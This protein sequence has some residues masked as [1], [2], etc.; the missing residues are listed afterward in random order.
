MSLLIDR[1]VPS[2]PR[3]RNMRRPGRLSQC[4]LA[5]G[6]AL[7][8]SFGVT[9]RLSA[10]HRG[11]FGNHD[12]TSSAYA[13][14]GSSGGSPDL[15]RD[16][17]DVDGDGRAD[18]C[19][20]VTRNKLRCS[21]GSRAGFSTFRDS[22]R[23][24]PGL[25]DMLQTF[26][27]VNADG[28]AD[29]CRFVGGTSP[30]LK[31]TVAYPTGQFLDIR[32]YSHGLDPGYAEMPRFMADVNGDGGADYCRFV[33]A[34]DQRF[35]SCALAKRSTIWWAGTFGDYDVNSAPGFSGLDPGYADM[36]TFMADVTAD[37]RADYCRF[38]GEDNARFL[39][40]AVARPAAGFGNHD[41]ISAAGF[42]GLDPGRGDMPRFMADANGDGRADYCRFVG[43]DPRTYFSCALATQS[44]RF[45]NYDLNSKAGSRSF[46]PGTADWPRLMV[47]ADGDSRSDYCRFVYKKHW[48][49]SGQVLSCARA[50]PPRRPADVPDFS[51]V[52]ESEKIDNIAGVR[53][54]LAILWDPHR[55][56]HPA[57]P[58]SEIDHLLFGADPSVRDWYRENSGGKIKLVRERVLGWYDAD[59]PADHYWD[60]ADHNGTYGDGWTDGHVEKWAE[61]IRRADADFDFAAYD[62]ND[63]KE[64]EVDELG[65]LIV[66]PQDGPFGTVRGTAGRQVPPEPLVVDGVKVPMIAEWYTGDPANLG[67]PAH[68][69]SHLF[70]GTPDLYM[71][72]RAWPFAAHTYSIMDSSYTTTHFDPFVKL[73]AGW[74]NY[75]VVT[76]ALASGGCC[77]FRLRDV[78]TTRDAIILYDPD[79]GPGEYFVLENRWRGSSYDTGR[80]MRGEGI[81]MD[82]LA[83][84]HII[85]DP[86]LLPL[87]NP[88]I[89][90]EGE[91]GRRGIR[92]VRANGGVPE[93][94]DQ[95]LFDD[96]GMLLGDDTS[97]ASLRWID[98][99]R[100]GFEIEVLS[101]AGPTMEIAVRVPW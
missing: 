54:V 65:V 45:G 101:A 8:L 92:L 76:P 22:P 96:E 29:Y 89:G 46:D 42:D 47:D 75:T 94:D 53:R 55:P 77:A 80:S 99:S 95:A 9:A 18:Y 79:R 61:A 28:R 69:L 16:I 74:L 23:I 43:E 66:I 31:C 78:Q 73:K 90:A 21:L 83:V 38:V 26:A 12:I 44:G 93:D 27:D 85:E 19:R 56:G 49:F 39:S 6:L 58:V 72:G 32:E 59:K 84:W 13:L 37:G 2:H 4:P 11:S 97:P 71:E 7:L 15:P 41:V 57:P 63:N 25:A 50:L 88:P 91:W 30:Y 17:A 64:L 62:L 10:D 1:P 100:T 36:P 34:D 48:I 82:G 98:G 52:I 68:E 86:G 24:D 3:V 87:S 40:C 67:A 20:F 81:P 51:G 35:L 60:N 33:G 14:L 70:I 5:L